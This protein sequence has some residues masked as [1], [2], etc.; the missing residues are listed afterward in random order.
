MGRLLAA[1]DRYG[2]GGKT[3]VV[4]TG[5]NGGGGPLCEL[6]CTFQV[7]TSKYELVAGKQRPS[8]S[9]GGGDPQCEFG[10]VNAPFLGVWQSQRGG[11][12]TTGKTS[13]WEGGHRVPGLVVW[14]GH[15][16]PRSSSDVLLPQPGTFL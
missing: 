10:G 12:G 7:V 2:F 13:T 16:P 5:D 15:V 3:L 14:P 6:T 4:F 11:G 9:A 8:V 1:V